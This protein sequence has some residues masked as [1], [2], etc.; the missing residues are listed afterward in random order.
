MVVYM[1]AMIIGAAWGILNIWAYH[2]E[3]SSMVKMYVGISKFM[4]MG[5]TFSLLVRQGV[6][7]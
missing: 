7:A 3:G 1:I 4:L 6:I 2:K 5:L